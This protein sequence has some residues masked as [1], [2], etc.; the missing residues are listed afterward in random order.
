MLRDLDPHDTKSIN[1]LKEHNNFFNGILHE[2]FNAYVKTNG[3][4]SFLCVS[5]ASGESELT[6]HFDDGD[7]V[8]T[9]PATGAS[10]RLTDGTDTVPQVNYTYFD[11]DTDTLLNAT[12]G[13]PNTEHVKIVFS[14]IQSVSQVQL[15][16]ALINQNWNDHLF[17]TNNM[18][19]LTHITEQI[20]LT[21]NGG[22]WHSGC[23]PV[24][25]ITPGSP[26]SVDVSIASGVI[27]QMHRHTIT[28]ADSSTGDDF[29]VVNQYGAP[30]D[31]INDLAEL[32]TDSTGASMSGKYFNL[33][34]WKVANKT[35][36]YS[37]MMINLPNGFYNSESDAISD[38]DNY[39]VFA[40]PHAFQQDSTTGFLIAR[41]TFKHTVAGGGTWTL[42]NTTDLRGLQPGTGAA[43]G[44]GVGALTEFSDVQFKI[45][46][47]I[48][49]TKIIQF[50]AADISNNTIRT[51]TVQD[52][53][54]VI[55]L[56][57]D[58]SN[59]LQV[60]KHI[61]IKPETVK[62]GAPGPTEAVIGN[63]PVLQFTT[64]EIESI[65][66]SFHIPI[67]WHIGTNINIQIYWA[68]VDGNAGTVVWQMNWDAVAVEAN[69]VISNIGTS[70]FI[71]DDTQLLQDELL[72]SGSMT[73]S[74]ADL[75]S[76]DTIGITIFR[77][78]DHPL[79][80]YE[81][82]ASLVQIEV[83]YTSDKL[84]EAT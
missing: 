13:W 12:G 1:N 24:V 6:A 34:L 46:D 45:L 33:V 77:D 31:G 26:D 20:R 30:F 38:V 54:G 16:G 64:A 58:I 57:G 63:F 47:D 15:D 61:E 23:L 2:T 41:F 82:S 14:Y 17:G 28:L 78:P 8:F 71:L 22:H 65:Y 66:T 56:V 29:H 18:G 84:G 76:E 39:D 44:G 37:P 62:L 42:N 5:G 25:T 21:S 32:L 19:H 48:D 70:A 49:P 80:D 11:K 55:A 79:D 60:K 7:H 52:T 74:G 73:I 43:G 36:Q 10:V 51:L 81:S 83:E 68:P 3:F 4:Y 50:Q 27:Y 40:I 75:A 9:I 72:E 59:A 69:E 53:D 35:G 67:D